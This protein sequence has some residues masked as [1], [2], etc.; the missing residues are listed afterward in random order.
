M[1]MTINHDFLDSL[2]IQAKASERLRQN[3][4]LRTS[5]DDDS[6]RM[7]NALWSRTEVPIHC[8]PKSSENVILLKGVVDEVIYEEV[9]VAEPG[10]KEL[11]RGGFE[12]EVKTHTVLR[13]KDRIRL[14]TKNGCLGYVV[15]AGVWH[16]VE[17][18]EPSVIYDA[19]D[20]RYGEDGTTNFQT[21]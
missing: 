5:P 11:L 16:K 9:T 2:L 6:Q 19:K 21:I 4:D 17:A 3:Y 1:H 14:D 7:L 18:I 20:K 8:H 10:N 13:E 12:P 15:P